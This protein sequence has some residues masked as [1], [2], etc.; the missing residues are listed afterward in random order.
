MNGYKLST[1]VLLFLFTGS[2][3]VIIINSDFESNEVLNPKRSTF[4]FPEWVKNN[5]YWWSQ[6]HIQ[7]NE[8]SYTMEYLIDHDVIKLKKC[9]GTCTN[10]NELNE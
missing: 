5:A 8:F 1:I 10:M 7:D 6:G 4:E 3:S 9:V 2:V